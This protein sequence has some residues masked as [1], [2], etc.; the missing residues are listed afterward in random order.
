MAFSHS[1]PNIRF[2]TI[3][4]QHTAANEFQSVPAPKKNLLLDYI[5]AA[6][7]ENINSVEDAT[8]EGRSRTWKRWIAWLAIVGW[9]GDPFLTRLTDAQNP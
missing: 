5:L 1:Q 6:E 2:F 4:F 8:H 3:S 9:V 7:V